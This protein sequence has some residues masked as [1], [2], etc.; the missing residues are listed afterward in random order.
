M[1]V[2]VNI[3]AVVPVPGNCAEQV[4]EAAPFVI[5][6]LIALVVSVITPL[7]LPNP[8]MLMVICGAGLMGV[9]VAVTFWA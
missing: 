7:P 3:T 9:N 8:T 2:A 6:Q 5:V 1:G 4:P